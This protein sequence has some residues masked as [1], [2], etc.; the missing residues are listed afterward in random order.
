[1]D[2][3]G[4]FELELGPSVW[5]FLVVLALTGLVLRGSRRHVHYEAL[6]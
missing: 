4:H 3:K 2:E 1:M 6:S 5:L